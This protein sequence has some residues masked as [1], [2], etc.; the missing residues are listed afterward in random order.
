MLNIS[1]FESASAEGVGEE[2]SRIFHWA[3]KS[4]PEGRDTTN[5]A[6]HRTEKMEVRDKDDQEAGGGGGGYF[7]LG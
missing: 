2:S 5:F 1:Y 3:R 7:H 6:R 4:N